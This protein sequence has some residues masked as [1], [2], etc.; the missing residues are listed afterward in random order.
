MFEVQTRDRPLIFQRRF[1]FGN[2]GTELD[3][4]EQRLFEQ[5]GKAFTGN[6]LP[7]PVKKKKN[8]ERK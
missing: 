3:Y 4:C 6:H 8:R 5:A 7:T 2:A 1:Y